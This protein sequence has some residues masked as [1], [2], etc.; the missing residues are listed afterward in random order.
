[1][2]CRIIIAGFGGQGVLFAGKILALSAVNDGYEVSWLPSYG[3][4]MRGGTANCQIVISDK[5]IS[6]PAFKTADILIALNYPSLNKFKN[7]V[8]EKI[9]TDSSFAKRCNTKAEIIG[10]NGGTGLTNMI[11]LGALTAK[12]KLVTSESII[13]AIH[14]SAGN[15]AEEDIKAFR[16]GV[17]SV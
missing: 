2:E 8:R 13:A 4:E 17:H 16:I 9:I 1:M 3:P 6:S 15:K 10:V 7:K 5:E 14:S 12:T 11:M